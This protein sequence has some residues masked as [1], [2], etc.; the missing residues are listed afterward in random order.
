MGRIKGNGD[1][2]KLVIRCYYLIQNEWINKVRASDDAFYESCSGNW[3]L[4]L[5]SGVL[6]GEDEGKDEDFRYVSWDFT[7]SPSLSRRP[8]KT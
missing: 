1:E 6:S 8:I 4:Q 5:L 7:I 3:K 2:Q